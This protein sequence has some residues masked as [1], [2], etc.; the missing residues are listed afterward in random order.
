M[1]VHQSRLPDV[2]DACD[3]TTLVSAGKGRSNGWL[4]DAS[5]SS[6][7]GCSVL[8]CAVVSQVIQ[9]STTSCQVEHK[10]KDSEVYP[11]KGE[12]IRSCE[13]ACLSRKVRSRSQQP[14]SWNSF[15]LLPRHQA[16]EAL[17]LVAVLISLEPGC[18]VGTV[19]YRSWDDKPTYLRIVTPRFGGF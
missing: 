10:K 16:C 18:F 19:Q 15:E 9:L 4:D 14:D 6:R 2:A 3:F 13:Q 12:I 17:E 1:L 5:N 8:C 11:P 7:V